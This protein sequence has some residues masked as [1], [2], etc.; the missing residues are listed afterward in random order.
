MPWMPK[1]T[2]HYE[3]YAIK[4]GSFPVWPPSPFFWRW[5]QASKDEDQEQGMSLRT[6]GSLLGRLCLSYTSPKWCNGP[7]PCGVISVHNN[8][9]THYDHK[10]PES[11]GTCPSLNEWLVLKLQRKTDVLR[12]WWHVK[13]RLFILLVITA[14]SLKK[15]LHPIEIACSSAVRRVKRI[16]CLLLRLPLC[17]LWSLPLRP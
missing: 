7:A 1:V 11:T 14:R 17:S 5:W 3:I 8:V 2:S 16:W 6:V 10:L 4:F 15:C 9:T 13:A 12:E